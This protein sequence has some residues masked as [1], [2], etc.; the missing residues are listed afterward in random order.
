MVPPVVMVDF[1]ATG[2]SFCSCV[3]VMQEGLSKARQ[4][5]LDCW[6][7]MVDL[8]ESETSGNRWLRTKSNASCHRL[9]MSYMLYGVI[10]CCRCVVGAI[11]DYY[12][13]IH[14]LQ[15]DPLVLSKRRG[16]QKIS[17]CGHS[18]HSSTDA[19]LL[20]SVEHDAANH[21]L[22]GGDISWVQQTEIKAPFRA[23]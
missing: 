17:D 9:H 12:W 3:P 4:S 10:C 15:E 16:S 1:T 13:I 7:N 2:F 6:N 19:R 5:L 23:T 14:H 21:H 22:H 8:E 11:I 18:T 20:A